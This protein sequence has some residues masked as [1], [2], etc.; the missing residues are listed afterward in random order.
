MLVGAAG[1]GKKW[2]SWRLVPM[3]DLG[4]EREKGKTRGE[5]KNRSG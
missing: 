5:E 1:G 3:A 2:V 4:R